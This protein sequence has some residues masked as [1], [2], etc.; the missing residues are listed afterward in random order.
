MTDNIVNAC[1]YLHLLNITND[2]AR[3]SL[4]LNLVSTA[5]TTH[6]AV[7]V[8]ASEALEFTT[9]SYYLLYNTPQTCTNL[10]GTSLI[11]FIHAHTLTKCH[12]IYPNNLWAY[13]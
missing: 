12:K 5:I 3:R 2:A 7:A 9:N 8:T 6:T 4:D 13:V 11:T 10:C 1:K